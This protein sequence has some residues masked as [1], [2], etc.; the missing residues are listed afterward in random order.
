MAFEGLSASF[1]ADYRHNQLP[2]RVEMKTC[3]KCK[4][5]KATTEFHKHAG[6]QD[7][8]RCQCKACCN[9]ARAEYRA[10]NIDKEIASDAKYRAENPCNVK[11][12]KAKWKASNPDYDATYYAKNTD[13]CKAANDKWNAANPDSR[14]IRAHNRRARKRANGGELSKCLAAKLFKLQKGKCACCGKPL[15]NGYQLDHVMPIALG[16][17]NTDANMQL[18]RGICNRQKHAKHPIDFMQERGFLL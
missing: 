16:G 13:K 7:G 11:A 17:S 6:K 9:A 5:A 14:R 3:T 8:L 10:V 18:L 4:E 12:T 2:E 15:G 1:H